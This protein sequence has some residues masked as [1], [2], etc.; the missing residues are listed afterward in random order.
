MGKIVENTPCIPSLLPVFVV[1]LREVRTGAGALVASDRQG[2]KANL[3]QC[4][5]AEGVSAKKGA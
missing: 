3:G 1:M 5:V 4:A 2:T